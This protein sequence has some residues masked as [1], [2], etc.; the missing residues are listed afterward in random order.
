MGEG[1]SATKSLTEFNWSFIIL[2]IM[3]SSDMFRD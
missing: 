3:S 2:T 1:I